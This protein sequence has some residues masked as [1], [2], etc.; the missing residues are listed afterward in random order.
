MSFHIRDLSIRPRVRY[1]DR[2]DV[3]GEAGIIGGAVVTLYMD[4]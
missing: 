1:V 3:E 4:M 2:A